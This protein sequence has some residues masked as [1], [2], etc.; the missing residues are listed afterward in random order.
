VICLD[1]WPGPD[2]EPT[3]YTDAFPQLA[4]PGDIYINESF[5]KGPNPLVYLCTGTGWV[6]VPWED[7]QSWLAPGGWM[8]S[9]TP[10]QN[11][12]SQ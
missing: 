6:P 11:L 1:P 8:K 4:S 7:W 12:P 3:V 10:V 2:W 5:K 9:P